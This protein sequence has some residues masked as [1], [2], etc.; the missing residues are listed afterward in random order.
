M[1]KETVSIQ[2]EK[3][4]AYFEKAAIVLTAA[5]QEAIE[6]ADFGLG[7]VEQVGL[8]LVTYINTDRVCAKD[9]VLLPLA[10][11]VMVLA[12]KVYHPMFYII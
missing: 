4:I 5:E 8:Q 1:T 11:M 9:M 6:V 10:S 2:Q 3:A 12:Y 7:I